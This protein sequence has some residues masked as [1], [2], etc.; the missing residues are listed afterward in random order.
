LKR[1]YNSSEDETIRKY[2]LKLLKMQLKFFDKNW[3]Q[4]NLYL[5]SHI[6]QLIDSKN[7]KNNSIENWLKYE[8]KDQRSNENLSIEVRNIII[9]YNT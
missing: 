3:R 4:E 2:C 1:I 8:K 7:D 5:I 6:Y 9:T